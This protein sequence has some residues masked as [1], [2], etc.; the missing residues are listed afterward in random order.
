[1]ARLKRK[2]D[3]RVAR[4]EAAAKKWKKEMEEAIN[5]DSKTP[6]KPPDAED[7][8]QFVEPRLYTTDVT[9]ERMA[10]LLQAR[11]QGMLLLTDELA[12]W[13]NNMRRYSGGDDTQF[14]LMAWDGKPYSV[15]RMGRPSFKLPRLLVG[16]VGGLQPGKLSD[17][18]KAD[19]GF[20]ARPLY[21]WLDMPPYRP[22]G[23]ANASDDE[24]VDVF[25]RLDRL[26]QH[27]SRSIDLSVEALAAFERL[28]RVVHKKV[29]LLDGHERE[30]F[31]KVPAQVL[32]LAGTLAYLGWAIATQDGAAEPTKIKQ[33]YVI[34]AVRLVLGYFWPHARAVLRQIG[35]TES[36][37]DARRIL[38]WLAAKRCTEASREDIRRHALGRSRNADQTQTSLDYLCKAG[39]LRARVTST[40]GR[41]S[42]R[43]EV[44]PKLHEV[45]QQ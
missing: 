1:M 33:Q 42:V 43:Y 38:H 22:L 44:N 17:L 4:A 12:G 6:R 8:G 16:V 39:W 45:T 21:A 26:G 13:L 10:V 27:E 31:A 23:D 40:G 3:E 9:V 20:Y 41:P 19:D 24:M 35:R 18:F 25:D 30:W 32:R 37:A 36:H 14:W 2:H 28:R 34:A 15:E 7:P 29:A 11:P 5:S